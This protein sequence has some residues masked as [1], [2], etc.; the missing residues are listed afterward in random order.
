MEA[1]LALSVELY[2]VLD[3]VS[4]N[5]FLVLIVLLNKWGTYTVSYKAGVVGFVIAIPLLT[6]DLLLAKDDLSTLE[7]F[8]DF[9]SIIGWFIESADLVL[10]CWA[11]PLEVCECI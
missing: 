4:I 8:S 7:R 6:L 2:R 11:K 1:D 5:K 3:F 9:T 10:P